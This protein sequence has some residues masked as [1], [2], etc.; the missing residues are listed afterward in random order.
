LA[1]GCNIIV[2]SDTF[3]GLTVFPKMAMPWVANP[4]W[5]LTSYALGIVLIFNAVIF[6]EKSRLA[7]APAGP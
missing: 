2:L 7:A 5:I 1:A 3:I 6:I 4:L